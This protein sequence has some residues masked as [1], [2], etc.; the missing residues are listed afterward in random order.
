MVQ[1]LTE[2]VSHRVHTE[3]RCTCATADAV[4]K[5]KTLED[6][7]VAATAEKTRA[8]AAKAAAEAECRTAYDKYSGES[9]AVAQRAALQTLRAATTTR[10]AA[11]RR[12]KAASDAYDLAKFKK[13]AY[14]L[15]THCQQ[16]VH[17]SKRYDLRSCRFLTVPL[18]DFVQNEEH[19][20]LAVWW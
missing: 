6:D 10:G 20:R 5:L 9:R 17:L 15:E 4:D 8:A 19:V 14:D 12:A 18:Q 1:L 2:T 3:A 11:E 7:L 13:H 16:L